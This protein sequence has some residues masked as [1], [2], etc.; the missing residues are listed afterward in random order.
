MS[1]AGNDTTRDAVLAAA[2][3]LFLTRGYHDTSM[4]AIAKAAGIS[5]G[6]LYFHF[7]NKAEIFC[8][9]CSQAHDRLDAAFQKA[10]ASEIFAGY[11]LR[12]IFMAYWDFFRTEPELFEIL[13][14]AE[15]SLSGIDLPPDMAEKI[16]DRHRAHVSLMESI[17]RDGIAAGE[18]KP[19]DPPS[20]ALFLHSVAE[21]VFQAYK[22]GLLASGRDG[23]DALIATAAG[24]VGEG[25]VIRPDAPQR[26][27]RP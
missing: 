4:R 25:M 15:N 1:T 10:V 5:T 11:K 14:L 6:P 22:N 20:L 3:A 13:H 24:V 12:A 2:R 18:L 19:F 23:L 9:I 17:I 21:G 8:H 27:D 7:A 16:A 26:D